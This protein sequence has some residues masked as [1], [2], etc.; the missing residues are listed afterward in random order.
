[1]A[2]STT[3]SNDLISYPDA[4]HFGN[5]TDWTRDPLPHNNRA[6][7]VIYSNEPPDGGLQAWTFVL[8]GFWVFFATFGSFDLLFSD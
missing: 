4:A 7:H 5:T 6:Q 2:E 3:E 1:M 8:S